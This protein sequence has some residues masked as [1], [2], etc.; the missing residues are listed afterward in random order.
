MATTL[1]VILGRVRSLCVAAP[2]SYTEAV[3]T[4]SFALDPTLGEAAVCK[5]TGRTGTPRGGFDF[6]EEC[7]DFLDLEVSRPVTGDY[8]VTHSTLHKDARS[9]TAAIVRDGAVTYGEYVISDAGRTES[10]IGQGGAAFL[11]LR[12]TLPVNYMSS[13]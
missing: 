13:L 5:V 1:D 8:R 4:E 11:T 9:L 12:L 6:Q 7:N 3:S 10:V 2:F